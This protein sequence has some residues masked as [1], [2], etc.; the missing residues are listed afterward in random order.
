MKRISQRPKPERAGFTLIELLVV[1]AIIAVLIALLLP[2]VQ[3]ARESARRTQ[4]KNNIKQL[5]TALHN[6][7]DAF[8]HFPAGAQALVYPK[9]TSG[10]TTIS[11][12]SWLVFIL[13]YIEQAPLFMSYDFTLAYNTLPNPTTVGSVNVPALYCASGFLP[14]LYLDPNANMTTNQS[15]HFVGVMGPAGGAT[16]PTVN[17]YNGVT[18][19]Y[20]VGSPGTNTAYSVE[21]LLGQYQDTSGSVTQGY[22]TTFATILDGSSNTLIV[23]EM[24]KTPPPGSANPYRSWIRGQAAGSGAT[25]NVTTAINST[26]YNGSNNFND[27]SF[28]SNHTSGCHFLYADGHVRF[29]SENIDLS[30]YK[31]LASQRSAEPI[32]EF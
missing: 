12:T 13:P 8:L 7:H 21:G 3:Q 23:G 29:I 30:L 27:I 14:K 24:S 26:F 18:Y 11:G 25:K 4:C 6:F 17:N 5:G 22:Y 28:S 9:G 2:A 10:P 20:T 1:I 32:A 19:N 15:S 31:A 16:S